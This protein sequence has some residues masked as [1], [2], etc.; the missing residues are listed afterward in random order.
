MAVIDVRG[1]LAAELKRLVRDASEW[2]I[3]DRRRFRNLLLDAVSSDAMPMAELLL[4]AHDEGLLRSFPDR[5]AAR[6]AWETATARLTSD[7]QTRSFVEPGVA[8]FVAESW[9]AALGPEVVPVARVATPRPPVAPRQPMRSSATLSTPPAR[10]TAPTSSATS[11]AS[12]ALYR[13]A[14]R[15]MLGIGVMFTVFVALAFRQTRSMSEQ[16]KPAPTTMPVPVAQPMATPESVLP[17]D[18]ASDSI[19]AEAASDIARM[20]SIRVDSS[21]VDSARRDA[22]RDPSPVSSRRRAVA[23]DAAPVRTT[24]DIVLNTGRVTEGRVISVRQQS[25]I[26]KDEETG[27]D[28]EIPKADIDRIVTREGRVMRFGDDNVPLIGDDDDLTPMS[29]A[30]RYRV[31]YAERWGAE[32]GVCGGVARTF[33]PGANVMINHL[34]GAPM[35]NM[36]FVD[37]L[38][39]N[40]TVR[41]DGLFETGSGLSRERGPASSFVSTRLSGRISRG[42]VL[43]GVVRLSAVTADGTMV[44]DIALTMQGERLP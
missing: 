9:A 21:R 32:R 39:F 31:R 4:R 15:L 42:G 43:R 24:D 26:V 28:F 23:V 5:T 33:A 37:G 3:R 25:V 13:R 36:V 41:S 38:G 30:G 12:L 18:P 29:H 14:N 19:V 8:R 10:Q 20:D 34:R 7:L 27:L 6:S 35:L 16:K 2:P 11:A 1:G 17:I 44:C 40:A 22:V